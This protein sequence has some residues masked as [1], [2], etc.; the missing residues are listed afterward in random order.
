MHIVCEREPL[1]SAFSTVTPVVRAKSPKP[2]LQNVKLEASEEGVYL[3][4]T[5]LEIGIRVAV[6][7][8]TIERGGE[9]V[10]PT[11]PF[12]AILRTSADQFLHLDADGNTL[13]VRGERSKWTL[14]AAD[15]LEYPQIPQFQQDAYHKVPAGAFRE[16]I[17]RTNF[18][19]DTQPGPKFALGGVALEFE[20][21]Q[22]LG[23]GTDGRRMAV[24]K[25]PA[26]VIGKHTGGEVA[27]IVPSRAMTIIERAIT[28][29][30]GDCLI[31]V[32]DNNVLVRS[33]DATIDAR[34]LEGKYP[35]W[36]DV[37]PKVGGERVELP[38]GP[39]DLVVQ[40][41]AVMTDSES[42][43]VEL[44]FSPGQLTLW[45]R[46]QGEATVDLPISYNGAEIQVALNHRF[47]TQF[48]KVLEP[49]ALVT[50]EVR[51]S[52]SAAMFSTDDGY[53]Y[54]VMP[55]SRGGD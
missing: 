45:A 28:Q 10:L 34:L 47:L 26:E 7:G 1:L 25:V 30:T 32:R 46:S 9:A 15:P 23:I 50:L 27:S 6:E 39:L 44:R 36:R 41:A 40:Q 38:V 24:V 37:L 14:P 48:F 35:R 52:E 42:H 51:D 17:R 19:T 21:D 18:A 33:Q 4:A 43:G 31:A 11:S 8:I 12:G 13:Q 49:D 3:L 2:I 20:D 22:V 53:Q 5:D 55:L 16:L 54:V 29:G